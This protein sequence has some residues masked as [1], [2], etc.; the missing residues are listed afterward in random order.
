MEM[1]RS[2]TRVHMDRDANGS[3]RP[4]YTVGGVRVDVVMLD[5]AVDELLSPQGPRSVH[6]CN[7][8]TISLAYKEVG[9]AEQLNRGA[10]N[11][12]DG[13]PL[14]W[15]ARRKGFSH[16]TD[17]ACGPD[18]MA[19]CID[20]GRAL[21]AKHYLFGST[22]EVIAQLTREIER[23][24]P[25]AEVVG[26]ESPPFG[27]YS[28][29][30]IAEAVGRF[31]KADADLVWVGLG[32]PKQDFEVERMAAVGN[33]T[34]VAIGAAFDFIA[35]S[36]DRP[37]TWVQKIGMEWLHRLVREPKRLGARYLIGNASF[38]RIVLSGR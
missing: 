33:Q 29:E 30:Q 22:P 9:Y 23:N 34:Y 32:T 7:A 26:A 6:L 14:V 21:G 12:C 2:D 15:L 18:L 4:S 35:G 5:E 11:L 10:L 1:L 16:M 20:R 13:M 36:K 17:R 38:I 19:A 25:G 8:Y 31:T 3:S 37:A 24:W 27:D 28:D